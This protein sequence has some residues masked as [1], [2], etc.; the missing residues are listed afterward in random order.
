MK[1]SKIIFTGVEDTT[2]SPCVAQESRLEDYMP[3]TSR[4]GTSKISVP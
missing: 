4:G 1:L 2:N 3:Q